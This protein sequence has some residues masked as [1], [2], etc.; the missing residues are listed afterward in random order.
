MINFNYIIIL[1]L[2]LLLY[3]CNSNKASR[4]LEHSEK[5]EHFLENSLLNVDFKIYSKN[6]S[7]FINLINLDTNKM[8]Y[9][10]YQ[11]ENFLYSYYLYQ[12]YDFCKK[13]S[14]VK[15]SLPYKGMDYSSQLWFTQKDIDYFKKLYD[16]NDKIVVLSEYVKNYISPHT[17]MGIQKSLDSLKIGFSDVDFQDDF[18]ELLYQY[19]FECNKEIKESKYK[20]YMFIMTLLCKRGGEPFK[21]EYESLK[22][23][24]NECDIDTN[25]LNKKEL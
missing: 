21:E 8:S 19:S 1:I 3:N 5:L 23:I 14:Y 24:L 2:S 9:R 20:K 25:V 18:Y 13:Y 16:T 11:Q 22:Y 6:D 4:K 12:D 10:D 7:L 17:S 15:F